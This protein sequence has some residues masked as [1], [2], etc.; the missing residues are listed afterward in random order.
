M[1]TLDVNDVREIARS[2]LAPGFVVLKKE[3]PTKYKFDEN[4]FE[5]LHDKELFGMVEYYSTLVKNGM[6]WKGAVQ[7]V[8]EK[9]RES[10]LRGFV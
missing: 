7:K 8:F 9:A 2:D 1:R 6:G 10:S 5:R 4:A 3:Q